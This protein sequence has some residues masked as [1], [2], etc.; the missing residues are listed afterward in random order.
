MSEIAYTNAECRGLLRLHT[1][2]LAVGG[3]AGVSSSAKTSSIAIPSSFDLCATCILTMRSHTLRLS[4]ETLIEGG[5]SL[6]FNNSF[7]WNWIYF[8]PVN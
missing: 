2:V 8:Y 5:N 7:I 4:G 1:D 3:C 6:L